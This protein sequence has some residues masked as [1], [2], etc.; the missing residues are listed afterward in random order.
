MP[1]NAYV[2]PHIILRG[3]PFEI[4]EQYGRAAHQRIVQHLANQ[5]ASITALHPD[6]PEWWKSEAR[7]YLPLYEALAPHL[8]EEM[9]GLA[10]GAELTFDD[11]LLLNLRDE[12]VASARAV[13]EDACTSFGVSGALTVSGE[14]I[15]GQTKDTAAVSADLY[16]VAAMYQK[17]RPDLLQMPYAGEVGVF[18]LSSAGMSCFGNSVYVKGRSRGKLPWELVRRL[19]LEADSIDAVLA[20]VDEYGIGTPGNLTIGDG[21]GRA[22]ALE[23]TDHGHAVVEAKDGLLVHANHI[24]SPLSRYEAYDEP[25]SS[26]S[27]H[28]QQR[29]TELLAAERGRL[30][31]PLAMRCLMDHVNYPRSICRHSSG[32]NDIQTTAALVVEPAAG[33][34]HVIRGQPCRGWPA[35]Y[36]L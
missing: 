27:H 36:S 24:D 28:R 25:E 12:L 7:S 3:A 32:A 21:T 17:G 1:Y 30:T 20:L 22:I 19:A 13:A 11:I 2:L 14:P 18:G 10:R 4:G 35:T 34:L 23:S 26:A 33:R 31:A 29:L 5:K 15:L 8:L 6:D 9:Q 16:V